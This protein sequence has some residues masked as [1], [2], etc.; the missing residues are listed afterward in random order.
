MLGEPYFR[1]ARAALLWGSLLAL[2]LSCERVTYYSFGEQKAETSSGGSSGAVTPEVAAVRAKVLSSQ[3]VCASRSYGSFAE[4]ADALAVAVGA[5]ASQPGAAKEEA[6]RAS[7]KKAMD[8]WQKAELILVGPA[9]PVT[10]PGGQA[11]REYVYSWPLWGRCLV[12]QN[13]V[14]K[15]Y[16]SAD[17]LTTALVNTRGLVALEYLLF[18]TAGD[19]A[20]SSA[21]SINSSGSW[22]AL[23]AAELLE[24]KADYASVLALD[25]AA[26]GAQLGQ[27]WS[28]SGGQF[29]TKLAQVQSPF[30]NPQHALNALSD[31]LFY[32]EHHTKDLKLGKPLGLV[33]CTDASCPDAVESQYA[34]VAVDH[35]RNNMLGFEQLMSGCGDGTAGFDDLLYAVG[36]G[37]VAAKMKSQREGVRAAA[38][39]LSS[40]DLIPL[41]QS[42]RAGVEALHAQLRDLTITLKTE[43]VGVLDLEIP[44]LVEGDND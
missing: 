4:A 27:A 12:E 40:A 30:A 44:K 29:E 23:S 13:L 2:G 14:S 28:A 41:L 34:R 19:N 42:D 24:R 25:V 35:I 17:F 22:A 39:A 1:G 33:D 16:E 31:G 36:A 11:Q 6:A 37:A 32:I 3:A 8:A 26:R 18:Y 5:L 43:F 21:S 10:A 38:N 15:A 7:W 9:A 20:C